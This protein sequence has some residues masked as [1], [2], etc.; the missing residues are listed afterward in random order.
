[1]AKRQSKW[2]AFLKKE[3]NDT[4]EDETIATLD[5]RPHSFKIIRADSVA[6]RQLMFPPVPSTDPSAKKFRNREA[7]AALFKA[8]S[9]LHTMDETPIRFSA[10]YWNGRDLQLEPHNALTVIQ[11]VRPEIIVVTMKKTFVGKGIHSSF[12]LSSAN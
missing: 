1:M 6:F 10:G 12:Y 4:Q 11:T 8:A 9:T 5:K 3:A 7:F 2:S